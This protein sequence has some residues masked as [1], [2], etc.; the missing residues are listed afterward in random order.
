MKKT[1]ACLLALSLAAC[2]QI[3]GHAGPMKPRLVLFVGFDV[4]ASFAKGS[5][6]N[7]AV[8]FLSVYL[9]AHLEGMGGLDVPDEPTWAPSVERSRTRPRPSSRRPSR[10]SS[11]R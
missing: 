2:A 7:D 11:P 9:H 1:L 4:S 5:Y 10:A 6:Y 3:T 8:D